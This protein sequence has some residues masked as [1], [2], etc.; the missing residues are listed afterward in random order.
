MRKLFVLT[1]ATMLFACTQ[2]QVYTINGTVNLDG[3]TEG[4][5]LLTVAS[6]TTVD[7]IAT[8]PIADG[9]FT[10]TGSVEGTTYSTLLVEGQRWRASI[11]LEA[12]VFTVSYGESIVVEGGGPSQQIANQINVIERE[13]LEEDNIR[14]EKFGE[15]RKAGNTEVMEAIL[16][17]HEQA[18]AETAAQQEAIIANNLDTYVAAQYFSSKAS[19]L[20]A[21]ELKEKYALLGENAKASTFGIKIK[22]RIAKVEA[23]EVGQIAPDFTLPTPDGGT[24]SLYEIKGKLKLIDF[25]ASWCGPCRNE[26]PNVVKL[27]EEYHPKGLEIFGV[28]L[29][30]EDGKDAWLKAIQ[31]DGLT[32]KHGSDLKF[33]QAAPAKLYVV[34]SIPHTVLL[35]EN[36]RIIA[37]D[38]R[39]ESLRAKV[40]ELLD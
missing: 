2:K 11:F 35:D 23:V 7:T 37:N 20:S 14:G 1:L 18:L 19:R 38:L 3:I 6:D 30:R 27:Y 22:D 34:N 39:G 13:F 10:I 40:A 28:S 29:D 31:D 17:E 15:A 33:W 5:A 36:N 12:G 24:I 8:A 4:K 25:W 32:W 26:N 21:A 9:K 16:K